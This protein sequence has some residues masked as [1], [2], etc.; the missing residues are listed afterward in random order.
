MSAMSD[1][2]A[3]E[4][5][6]ATVDAWRGALVVE[7]GA[8][9]CAHCQAAQPHVAAALAEYPQVAHQKV[10]DGRGKPLGRSFKVKLWPTLIFLK[11][12]VEVD[13]LVRPTA[14]API[15]EALARIV[16]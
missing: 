7:F 2:L 6:R 13:R 15:R 5:E 16:P 1:F 12:G 14:S 9:W 8:P 10:E 4:P 11:D 3:V